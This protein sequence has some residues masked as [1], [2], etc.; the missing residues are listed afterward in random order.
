MTADIVES[1]DLA[2]TI[3]DNEEIIASDREPDV[4]SRL[5]KALFEIGS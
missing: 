1:I 2:F 5:G 4:F 3:L